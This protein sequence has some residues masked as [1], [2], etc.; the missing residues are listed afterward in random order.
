MT[1]CFIGHRTIEKNEQLI[2]SLREVVFNLIQRGVTTFLFGSVSEFDKLAWE[3]VTG[4][5]IHFPIINRIY[6][7]SSYQHIDNSYEKY[8]LDSYEQ[9]YYPQQIESAGKYSYVE[10][11]CEMI[12]KSEYCVFY[13]NA[14]YI[15]KE[16][17]SNNGLPHFSSRK[18]GTKYAFAYAQKKKKEIINLYQ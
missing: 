15:P 18:S 9:T 1:A 7:R 12:D 14:N 13:Y 4:L 16:K 17:H 11:N 6:V 3:I 10:R 5:K 8:I 2:S